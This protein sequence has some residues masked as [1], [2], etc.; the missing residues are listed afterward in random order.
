MVQQI[1]T[2]KPF[3]A[4]LHTLFC[5]GWPSKTSSNSKLWTCNP[6]GLLW[7]LPALP[8][9]EQSPPCPCKHEMDINDLNSKTHQWSKFGKNMI[10]LLLC[11]VCVW[12]KNVSNHK[13]SNCEWAACLM[14]E[15]CSTLRGDIVTLD[16]KLRVYINLLSTPNELKCLGKMLQGKLGQEAHVQ[17]SC[18]FACDQIPEVWLRPN[19]VI[20][21]RPLRISG[22]TK[23]GSQASPQGWI[24][25]HQ[26]GRKELRKR[27]VAIVK[28]EFATGI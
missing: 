26:I 10:T 16:V 2:K 23:E 21:C 27:P 13:A 12:K 5:D 17:W 4:C 28:H 19:I 3:P 7:W 1:F 15:K 22:C 20:F 18:C 14:A 8:P 24:Q 25:D 9:T 11:Q 6:Q